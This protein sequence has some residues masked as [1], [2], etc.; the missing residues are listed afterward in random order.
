MLSS[1]KSGSS[2]D[3][4]DTS[5]SFSNAMAANA[6]TDTEGSGTVGKI[7]PGLQCLWK[8]T[9]KLC[10]VCA[11]M[12]MCVRAR[13]CLCVHLYVCACVR[14]CVCACVCVCV[15]VCACAGGR[16]CERQIDRERESVSVSTHEYVYV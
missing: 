16:D 9:L 15:C 3:Y 12:L 7:W 6:G 14:V 4:A 10:G 1:N 5:V 8:G 13:A 11:W 2:P